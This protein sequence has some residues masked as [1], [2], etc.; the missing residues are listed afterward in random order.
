MPGVLQVPV[1]IRLAQE[2][3]SYHAPH[4][5]YR[6]NVGDTSYLIKGC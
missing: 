4:T 2:E 3:K 6:E 1:L 5:L